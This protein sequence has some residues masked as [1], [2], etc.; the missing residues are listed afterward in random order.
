MKTRTKLV[1]K[2]VERPRIWQFIFED[3]DPKVK[4]AQQWGW[5]SIQEL[6]ECLNR[7]LIEQ[8]VS[9]D[10]HFEDNA[11]GNV[12]TRFGVINKHE[13]GEG[14]YTYV[15]PLIGDKGLC[16][17][18]IN[19]EKYSPANETFVPALWANNVIDIV[20]KGVIRVVDAGESFAGSYLGFRADGSSVVIEK[21]KDGRFWVTNSVANC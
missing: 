18:K 11:W 15:F 7:M 3:D 13:A 8:G 2:Q 6:T 19:E 10:K 16:D 1:K 5:V 17:L 4:E 14:V 20:K 12:Y 9:T 21:F